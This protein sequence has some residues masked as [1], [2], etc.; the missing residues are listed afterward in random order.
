MPPLLLINLIKL[1]FAIRIDSGLIT[2]TK[3]MKKISLLL[4][5]FLDNAYTSFAKEME[6][7]EET[8]T[9]NSQDKTRSTHIG[10]C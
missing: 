7:P 4:L 2:E 1:E 6:T 10:F 3:Q 8:A 9:S 5:L